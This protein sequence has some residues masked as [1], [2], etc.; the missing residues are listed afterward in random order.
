MA[1]VEILNSTGEKKEERVLEGDLLETPVK[2]HLLYEVVKM[3]LACK[4][5][6]TASTKTRGEVRGGGRKPWRQKGTGRSRQGS[7]RA[8][9]W[10]GGGAVFGPRP[11][12]FS[13]RVPRKARRVALKSAL[14]AKY[15]DGELMFVEGM[16]LP[17]HKTKSA[18]AFLRDLGLEGKKVL[19]VIEEIDFN[20]D[21]A[22]GNLPQVKVLKAEG[23]NVYDLLDHEVV[24]CTKGALDR[25]EEAL[26]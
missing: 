18:V 9:H 22:T 24:V 25:I 2:T 15:G 14:S 21:K 16:D 19:L 12:G 20:L 23:L 7:I 11:R 5:R 6:G 3:Q 10:V 17:D 8:P 1:T 26:A 13:Y 4:R